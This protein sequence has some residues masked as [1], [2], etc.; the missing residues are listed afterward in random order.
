[1]RPLDIGIAFELRSDF[2]PPK[3]APIDALEEYDSLATIEALADALT[4]LGHHPRLLRGGRVFLEA[5]LA[6]PPELVFNNAEGHGS[7]SREAQVPAIC[8][9]LGVPYSHSD[10]LTMALALDKALAKRVV[11]SAGIRTAP[12]EVFDSAEQAAATALPLPLF[13]KPVAEGSSMGVRASSRVADRESLVQEVKRCLAAYRQPV[14]VEGYLASVEVTVGV[15]G[16][17]EHA[18]VLGS[19]EIAPAEAA[20]EDFVYG[21]ESKRDYQKLVRYYAPPRSLSASQSADA[22]R[23]ALAAYRAL[24]CR[25]VARVDLRF[26]ATGRAN[27]IEINPLPGLNPVTGDLVVMTKLLGLS[28]RDL[29]GAIVEETLRRYPHLQ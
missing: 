22:E 20:V 4:A 13:V 10:P 23:T 27:F 17:A 24:G 25:D 29:I 8:E 18:R 7:R 1:M 5:M 21:L 6:R 26:D 3:N 11:Q 15:C 28:Y 2:T 19:M 14:L 9:L 16:S 12:F